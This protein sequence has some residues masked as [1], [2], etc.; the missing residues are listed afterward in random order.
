MNE[1][2]KAYG[3]G[4]QAGAKKAWPTHCP[5]LPPDVITA[6]IIKAAADLR[7]AADGICAILTDDDD[8]VKIL[9][10]KIDALDQANKKISEWIAMQQG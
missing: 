2:G 1:Y 3:K 4:Y 5:P 9:S 6:D 10:P 8:F 7:N